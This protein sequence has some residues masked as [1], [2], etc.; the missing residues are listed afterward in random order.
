MDTLRSWAFCMVILAMCAAFLALVLLEH[1][2]GWLR[3]VSGFSRA[4]ILSKKGR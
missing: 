1:I 3:R 4:R 2:V